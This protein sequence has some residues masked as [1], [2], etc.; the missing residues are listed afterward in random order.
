V[1]LNDDR[2]SLLR[3]VAADVVGPVPGVTGSA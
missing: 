2:D 3:D 1:A